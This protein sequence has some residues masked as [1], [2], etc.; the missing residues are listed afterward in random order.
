MLTTITLAGVLLLG[1]IPMRPCTTDGDCA[2]AAAE[3][4]CK[5][6]QG[7][8]IFICDQKTYR[9]KLKQVQS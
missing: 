8:S 2:A 5:L 6:D 9:R 7:R 4:G 1:D 3:W